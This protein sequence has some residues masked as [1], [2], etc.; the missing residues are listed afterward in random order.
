[1]AGAIPNY[2]S[3]NIASGGLTSNVTALQNIEPFK[4]DPITRALENVSVQLGA[5]EN[6][7]RARKISQ[8]GLL[9]KQ[10][11]MKI[12]NDFLGDTDYETQ[13]ERFKQRVDD[14]TSSVQASFGDDA[15]AYD[16]WKADFD[17]D[18]MKAE[19]GYKTNA[20]GKRR[21]A[22]EAG[23]T[24][25]LQ[26]Y[27]ATAAAS[28]DPERA[29]LIRNEGLVLIA[30]NINRGVISPLAGV[31][32]QRKYRSDLVGAAV[33]EQIRVDPAGAEQELLSGGFSDLQGEAR[34]KLIEMAGNRARQGSDAAWR[35]E[36]RAYR[37]SER[38]RHE[39]E[40]A[41]Q[42]RGDELLASGELTDEWVNE[43]KEGMDVGD[44]RLYK[45]ELSDKAATA[46]DDEVYATHLDAIARGENRVE[47]ARGDLHAGR[48]TRPSYNSIMTA[49][50]SNDK[51]ALSLIRGALTPGA[52]V[53]DPAARF[54]A[55]AAQDEWI[56]W[57]ADHPT[58]TRGERSAEVQ[59]IIK[60]WS[61]VNWRDVTQIG[62]T[63]RYLVGGR[64]DPDINATADATL[65]AFT[66][67]HG[68][69]EDAA[70]ADPALIE[71]MDL[72]VKWDAAVKAAQESK[73][74]K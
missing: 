64:I 33:R 70:L 60:D 28:T 56:K 42:F 5:M 21:V 68:G 67:L 65:D 36:E 23:L 30:D 31:K 55:S 66:A 27:A 54:R 3:R 6:A 34:T 9:G 38:A 43:N 11:L 29:A 58:A 61:L 63:P 32:M 39:E 15:A 17:L 59:S 52:M 8:T 26:N 45:N 51:Q 37:R 57:D 71:Q 14:Y 44:Y 46:T 24:F 47:A 69:D 22:Q 7:E 25:D 16:V 74:S 53:K 13:D 20:L 4:L 12:E 50:G 62:K 18:A 72:I 40:R 73:G 10:E 2:R 49:Q 35:N 19:F 48:I 41:T 1:M